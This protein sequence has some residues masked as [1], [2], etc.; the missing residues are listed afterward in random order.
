MRESVHKTFLKSPFA[1]FDKLEVSKADEEF[2]NHLD[3]VISDKIEDSD[4]SIDQLAQEMAMSRTSL[5]KKIRGIF[6]ITPNNYIKL[7]RLK[8]AAH[9]L[10]TGDCKINEVCYLVGFTSPS[11]FTQ[12]FYKQFGLLPKDFVN[13]EEEKKENKE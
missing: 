8:K 9:L 1:S 10:K 11:Y 6:N 3:K 7:N 12:C 13:S 5:N 4:F 2:V